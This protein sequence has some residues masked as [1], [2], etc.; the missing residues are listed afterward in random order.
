MVPGK[1]KMHN[2]W[3]RTPLQQTFPMPDMENS[4]TITLWG[5]AQWLHSKYQVTSSIF[6]GL[7]SLQHAPLPSSNFLRCLLLFRV[8]RRSSLESPQKIACGFQASMSFCESS[9]R[10]Q[11]KRLPQRPDLLCKMT[12]NLTGEKGVFFFVENPPQ[13]N[14]LFKVSLVLA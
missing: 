7:M 3:K 10:C 6:S 8:L 14:S 1:S 9:V 13:Q 11:E 4:E 5:G 12:P 2:T